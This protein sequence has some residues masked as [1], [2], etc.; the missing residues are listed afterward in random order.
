VQTFRNDP[1]S[2]GGV[3][4]EVGGANPTAQDAA[5]QADGT[6]LA[7][8][9]AQS[10]TELVVSGADVSNVD[11]GFNFDTI[12]N[13]NDSGQGSLRQFLRN[14]N[15]LANVNLDQEDS[16]A[17]VSAVTKNAGDEHSIFMIPAGQLV[18][19]ID[20]GGGTVM[21]VQPAI[22]L[23]PITDTNTDAGGSYSF[24]GLANGT[25]RIRVVN[26]T[27]ASN[28]GSNGI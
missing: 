22:A 10:V 27:V 13:T 18:A 11:F 26:S 4:G 28:R 6:N 24:A 2:G 5:A 12:V 20:G 25:Y 1:D 19:T 21:L 8:I 16:P 3:T 17:G 9:T 23:P 15:E 14:S 7:S